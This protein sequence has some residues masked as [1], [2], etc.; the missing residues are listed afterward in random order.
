[1]K[2]LM[3][4]GSP[5]Q[6]G[7][8]KTVKKFFGMAQALEAATRAMGHEVDIR[9]PKLNDPEEG[10]YDLIIAGYSC[11]ASMSGRYSNYIVSWIGDNANGGLAT[12][13]VV[14]MDDWHMKQSV[15]TMESILREPRRIMD[16]AQALG[17]PSL[18]WLKESEDNPARV[19]RGV[20]AMVAGEWPRFMLHRFPWGEE[21]VFTK[22]G[23]IK[24]PWS[25]DPSG[26]MPNYPVEPPDDRLTE[27]TCPRLQT[28]YDP[29]LDELAE[30]LEWPIT[31]FGNQ[32]MQEQVIPESKIPQVICEYAGTLI[33]AGTHSGGGLWR[34]RY[35]MAAWTKTPMY[36][37]TEELL[38]TL[39]AS[40]T[41]QPW[42]IEKMSPPERAK[43]A[44]AQAKA[45][46]TRVW[47]R[48]QFVDR[49][50]WLFSEALGEDLGIAPRVSETD[51]LPERPVPIIHPLLQPV[52]GAPVAGVRVSRAAARAVKPCCG[53]LTLEAGQQMVRGHHP[54]CAIVKPKPCSC[55]AWAP[56]E[57]MIAADAAA[58]EAAVQAAEENP[59]VEIPVQ[60]REHHSNCPK[61]KFPALGQGRQPR[62]PRAP[63]VR[64]CC[65]A[66]EEVDPSEMV[67]GHHPNC[68]RVQPRGN[69]PPAIPAI[70]RPKPG[71]EGYK[72]MDPVSGMWHRPGTLDY[73]VIKEVR[74][75]QQMGI[76]KE[77]RVLD[78]GG[79]IGGFTT[80]AARI[81]AEV[82]VYEPDPE[83]FALLEENTA[84][85]NGRVHLKPAALTSGGEETINLYLN[86]GANTGTHTLI[87][88]RGR[89]IV[90]VPAEDYQTVLAEI[91]PTVLKVDI[92]GWEY[93]LDFAIPPSVRVLCMELHR[94]KP[95]HREAADA[96]NA[97]VLEQGFVPMKEPKLT[98]G[99]WAVLG[100]WRRVSA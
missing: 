42:D 71:E 2:I 53:T 79:H 5:T 29:W 33:P 58:V 15:S 54:E 93:K 36:A 27:W 73:Y 100:I 61:L 16:K 3:T 19:L 72:V 45:I 83:N 94:M 63:R 34:S 52:A 47:T 68:A 96:L 17:R 69:L 10:G 48:Q 78:V 66:M 8:D 24:Q 38:A 20:Q 56:T 75:Y 13:M 23:R 49:L 91:Q 81:G 60:Q 51:P 30:R 32:R 11:L 39:D 98:G 82:W 7:S 14:Y 89:D 41:V 80:L 99:A 35:L 40:F 88:T 76:L 55:L 9:P 65:G 92:E 21:E 95:G 37:A 6:T 57:E 90:E 62:E 18:E 26:F 4:G 50:H 86:L 43:L 64:P 46:L 74:A 44:E 84:A 12:P 87:P 67:R 22:L 59:G 28:F 85:Y 31:R 97:K 70:E 1:V 77:D 25:M